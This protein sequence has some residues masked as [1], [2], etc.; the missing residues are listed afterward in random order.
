MN[1]SNILKAA[2][3][4]KQRKELQAARSELLRFVHDH[5][6]VFVHDGVGTNMAISAGATFPIQRRHFVEY[7]ESAIAKID[8]ILQAMGI[9]E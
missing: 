6:T 4:I 9:S 2:A 1:E 8:G 7:I 5:A 3:Y